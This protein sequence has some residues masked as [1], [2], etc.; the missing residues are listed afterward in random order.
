LSVSHKAIGFDRRMPEVDFDTLDLPATGTLPV[1]IEGA[2]RSG[3]SRNRQHP[4]HP[5]VRR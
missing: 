5:T 2:V 1:G 3:G 4:R